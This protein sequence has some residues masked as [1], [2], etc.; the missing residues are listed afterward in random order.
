MR[1]KLPKYRMCDFH[2]HTPASKCFSKESGKDNN[3]AYHEIV[4]N[5]IE[6]DLSIIAITD[7]NTCDGYYVLKPIFDAQIAARKMNGQKTI[8][9]GVEITCMGTHFLA[10]FSPSIKKESI[11]RFLSDCG[12]DTDDNNEESS[13]DL[14]SPLV[15][16]SLVKKYGGFI[17]IPHC[18][19]TN[20]LLYN[21]FSSGDTVNM[22][23][24]GKSVQKILKHPA[25]L[26][27]CYNSTAILQRLK[28]LLSQYGTTELKLLQSSDSHCYLD[29]ENYS[30]I[31]TSGTP[32]G[33]RKTWIKTPNVNYESLVSAFTNKSSVFYCCEPPKSDK[34]SIL[35]ISIANSFI[36]HKVEPQDKWS[37]LTFSDDLTC[38][39]GPRG[40][41]KTTI[42]EYIQ[43]IENSDN[44]LP[45][46]DG[47]L[48]EKDI[49]LQ[50]D[51]LHGH[52]PRDLDDITRKR[53]ILARFSEVI[54]FYSNIDSDFAF[55]MM[56]D[57]DGHHKYHSFYFRGDS[58]V[59][60]NS[61]NMHNF[62]G[63]A[64]NLD[65]KYI[66]QNNTNMM[67]INQREIEKIS[68]V[69]DHFRNL[70]LSL[71]ERNYNINVSSCFLE[72]DALKSKIEGIARLIKQCIYQNKDE[73]IYTTQIIDYFEKYI[74]MTSKVENEINK[75]IEQLNLH[76][77]G[78]LKIKHL[79]KY[80]MQ[81]AE[82]MVNGWVNDYC[83]NNPGF[84]ISEANK[85][86]QRLLSYF[87]L[88]S[89]PAD[90]IPFYLFLND[91]NKLSQFLG[92]EP[93]I[94]ERLC[95]ITRRYIHDYEVIMRPDLLIS[96]EFNVK[97]GIGSTPEYRN[98]DQL[99]Y[100]QKAV[101]IL[102]L[103][104]KSS[105]AFGDRRPLLIDQPEDDL[106]NSYVYST[107]VKQ[108]LFVKAERQLIITT[109]NPNVL[110][111]C[112]SESILVLNSNG[113]SA[114]LTA[115]GTIDKPSVREEV[116][117]IL[118]GNGNAL[119]QRL[120]KYMLES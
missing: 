102:S 4:Y 96:Y 65:C 52:T 107:L 23:I 13:A 66:S 81:A 26:G 56:T 36:D 98:S 92:A 100:G 42:L 95:A 82:S 62:S 32:M 117:K 67:Y 119:R 90:C 84:H 40:A 20:G 72:I 106:D 2:I 64:I 75:G 109:H 61:S 63:H 101:C 8:L 31:C 33:T 97:D 11:Q 103:I 94:C 79:Y 104:I 46:Y 85:E 114:K 50:R 43:A 73:S 118:E 6:S 15:L 111:G 108:F 105:T 59:L 1:E 30:N 18:D 48:T 22:T 21:K 55:Y 99:S 51:L 110:V 35:G 93:S 12:L 91:P 54:Q 78:T 116:I 86:S 69:S 24:G 89:S 74:N 47:D 113:N 19:S 14:V 76:N 71:C 34:L 37:N 28:D 9:P 29:A 112:E 60:C 10:I 53:R 16:C 39:I 5:F 58:A 87:S 68:S 83:N 70:I 45:L 120:Q 88:A 17:I 27:L 77:Q 25:V 3:Y 7:H 38:I 80:D 44:I 57:K 41:G 49:N 115:S